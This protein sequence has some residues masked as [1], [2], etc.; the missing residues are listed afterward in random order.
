MKLTDPEIKKHIELIDYHNFFDI[1]LISDCNLNCAF[2]PRE[3][4]VRKQ[5]KMTDEQLKILKGWLPEKC[6]IMFSGMGEPLID[7]RIFDLINEFASPKRIIGITTNAQL[8][9]KN[10][11][12]KLLNSNLNFLQISLNAVDEKTYYEISN[13]H[14][15]NK[16]FES[17]D[18]LSAHK[19]DSLIIQLSLIDKYISKN[20]LEYLETLKQ[21]TGFNFFIKKQHNRGGHLKSNSIINLS[22]CYLFSQFTFISSDG[23]ILSCCHDIKSNS[24]LGNIKTHSFMEITEIKK[25]IIKEN[26]W[27]NEC[28]FCN[29]FGRNNIIEPLI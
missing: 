3:K 11:T 18:Y 28:R 21:K 8:L 20:S 22:R 15:N 16:I 24:I 26:K 2:C 17:L 27:F 13:G 9:N 25:N 10:M 6:N 4:I 7:K 5:K 23:N 12:Q 1:E 29:D 14:Q 19:K